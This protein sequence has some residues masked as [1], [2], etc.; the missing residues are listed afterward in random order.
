NI[1]QNTTFVWNV[2]CNDTLSVEAFAFSNF[3][4]HVRGPFV[5]YQNTTLSAAVSVNN[6]DPYVVTF[7]VPLQIDLLEGS[8]SPMEFTFLVADDNGWLDLAEVNLT[9]YD[10]TTSILDDENAS[11]HYFS[12]CTFANISS[13]VVNA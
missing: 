6:T 8:V 2:K 4:V 9:F 13:Y 1:A 5:W 10:A 11:Y 12:N 7:G 3:T